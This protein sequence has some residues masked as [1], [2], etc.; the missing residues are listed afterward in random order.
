MALRGS[1]PLAVVLGSLTLLFAA[2]A[3]AQTTPPAKPATP[4]APAKGGA[5]AK[6]G[7]KPAD[8]AASTSATPAATATTPAPDATPAAAPEKKAEPAEKEDKEDVNAIYLSGDIGFTRTDIGGFSDS[9]GLDKT[10]ANG[11]LAGLGVGYR[12]S[13]FRFGAR[14]RDLSTTQFSLWSIMG[15]VGYGLPMR[16]LAPAFYVHL[17]Y[18][19]DTGVER[20]AFET[21]LPAGNIL[22]PDIDVNGVVIGGEVVASYHLSHVARIGPFIGFD[23]LVIHRSRPNLPQ[24]LFQIPPAV[25]NNELFG[26]SGNGLGYTLNI[27]VRLTADIGFDAAFKKDE[28]AAAPAK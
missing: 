27:G 20:G 21:K 3:T 7:A 5:P 17:G 8:A 15:E 14:F 1:R 22:T 12:R 25:A 9:T 16:P 24:A 26:E 6:P 13:A 11:L 18:M 10:G 23:V 19:F 28:P 4:A 2:P